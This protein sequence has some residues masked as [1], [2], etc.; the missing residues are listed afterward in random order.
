MNKRIDEVYTTLL[1]AKQ[2]IVE[3]AN[4]K[5]KNENWRPYYNSI[6]EKL[7]NIIT[8]YAIT[9]KMSYEE[10]LDCLFEIGADDEKS[11][12]HDTYKSIKFNL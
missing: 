7:D 5:V 1:K 12:F 9:T 4:N 8:D 2:S 3:Y 6:A 11:I 10:I